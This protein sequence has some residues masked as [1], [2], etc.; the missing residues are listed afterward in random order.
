MI[1]LGNGIPNTAW[2]GRIA[3]GLYFSMDK[4]ALR[5]EDPSRSVR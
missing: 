2:A 5:V 1:H 3:D 4:R